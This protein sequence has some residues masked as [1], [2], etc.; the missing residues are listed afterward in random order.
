MEWADRGR[1][2]TVVKT[3]IVLR[4]WILIVVSWWLGS[5]V[6]REGECGGC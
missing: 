2:G 6:D 5:T 4:V 3:G 1:S